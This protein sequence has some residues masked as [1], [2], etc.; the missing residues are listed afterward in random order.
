VTFYV[1]KIFVFGE[2]GRLDMIIKIIKY[3]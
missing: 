1:D 3:N 2:R